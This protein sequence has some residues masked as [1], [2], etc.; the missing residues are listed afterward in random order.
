[1]C[2]CLDERERP[3][4]I[5]FPFIPKRMIALIQRVHQAS[6]EV[7]EETV[8]KIGPGLLVLLGV[9]RGDT[10]AVAEELA[11]KCA[12]LRIFPGE[13][14]RMDRSLLDTGGE[15]L[16]VPQFTLC[17]DTDASGNRPSFTDAAPPER[18]RPL[19][20]HFTDELSAH[21]SHPVPTGVFGAT[22]NVHLTNG[23]PVTLW[24]E[25]RVEGGSRA[26]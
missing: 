26:S 9:V 21:L 18:A 2:S 14:G 12:A 13:D 7:E 16:V 20:E 24:L 15:A 8:G 1:M 23:G 25:R 22:M 3:L 6:V 10:E 11:R 5:L 19:Y 4:A 17:A